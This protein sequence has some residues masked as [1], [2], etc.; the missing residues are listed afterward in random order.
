MAFGRTAEIYA[1]EDRYI[2]KLFQEWMPAA[3]VEYE[4]RSARAVYA[5]GLPVPA[6]GEIIAIDG[7]LGLIYARVE[8]VSMRELICTKPWTFFRCA[9]LLAELHADM[10]ACTVPELPSQRQQFENRI[11]ETEQL[12]VSMKRAVL[13][14]LDKMPDDDRLCHG[15]FHMNNILMTAEGP[16]VID[17]MYATRGHPLADVA[18]T[19]LLLR[20]GALPSGTPAQWL[21]RAMHRWFLQAYLKG[22]F[23]LRP[24]DRGQLSAWQLIVAAGR[25]RMN[26]T[27]EQERL[28]GLINTGLSRCD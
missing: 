15:D 20:I 7:R 11:R 23:E 6:V 21:R 25:L 17:W 27:E 5:A 16:V 10:H 22:Y 18:K 2:V 9:R 24:G 26:I 14:A 3:W 1:W 4:A 12:P 13:E 19:A 8:G 28:M